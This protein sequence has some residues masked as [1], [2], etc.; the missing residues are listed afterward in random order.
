MLKQIIIISDKPFNN[1]EKYNFY[2]DLENNF[3]I[4]EFK[5]KEIENSFELMKKIQFVETFIILSEKIKNEFIK[6][7]K[8][9]IKD[10]MIIPKIFTISQNKTNL[11]KK[12]ENYG[13]GNILHIKDYILELMK[14]RGEDYKNKQN[15]YKQNKIEQNERY[16]FEYN[17]IGKLNDLLDNISDDEIRKYNEWLFEEFY[18]IYSPNFT[19]QLYQI[20]DI[21]DIPLELLSKYYLRF[22]INGF[23][24]L[25]DIKK[26]LSTKGPLNSKFYK[27]IKILYLASKLNV[28]EQPLK[29]ILY[30]AAQIE[31]YEIEKIKSIT[32]FGNKPIVYAKRFLSFS[33]SE[34]IVNDH[35]RNNK[36]N[37]KIVLE[38]NNKFI[39]QI[40][41]C[42]NITKISHLKEEEVLFFPFSAFQITLFKVVN[43]NEYEI[44]LK[45][46]NNKELE[47]KYIKD[48]KENEWRREEE[49]RKR[50][51][52]SWRR[53]INKNIS[54]RSYVG[55]KNLDI[56]GGDEMWNGLKII[57]WDAHGNWNQ[58]FKMVLNEDG[59]VSFFNRN[60]AIDA[61]GGIAKNG[62]QINIWEKN[63]SNAQKYYIEDVGNGWYR[64]HSAIN[65]NYCIDVNGFCSD[66]GT[67]IQLWEKNDSIAQKFKFIE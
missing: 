15:K 58:K 3:E 47:E 12:F 6:K 36:Y 33:E 50:S 37:T 7:F 35:K 32:K 54:I 40:I 51:Q 29:S 66:N 42:A 53:Y 41:T 61:F 34:R 63:S 20:I 62:T 38:F 57:L 59:S 65:Y 23:D 16:S 2:K 24:F 19:E 55:N 44:Y 14:K 5:E 31:D 67:K 52:E 27:Y 10:F 46:L 22:Y 28:F 8:S 30:H 39:D 1:V 18:D 25:D 11:N 13:E 64:I 45:Y 49:E 9:N 60:F 17:E 43:I 26:D 21:S 56:K 4:K 48:N